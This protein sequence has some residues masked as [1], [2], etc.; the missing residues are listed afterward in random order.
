M[1]R[2][3]TNNRVRERARRRTT[4]SRVRIKPTEGRAGAESFHASS[5]VTVPR[6]RS[7]SR[8]RTRTFVRL[9]THSPNPSNLAFA[10]ALPLT[11]FGLW[12]LWERAS[13]PSFQCYQTA[14]VWRECAPRL[15]NCSSQGCLLLHL[16][17][18][19][20]RNSERQDRD[21]LHAHESGVQRV[22]RRQ[23]ACG[24]SFDRRMCRVEAR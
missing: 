14:G 12:V 20:A 21:A 24:E 17:P 4:E 22:A 5:S 2:V 3:E 9:A 15:D 7:R 1:A 6:T 16:S 8:S 23:I 13:E 11:L 10:V 18:R 19:W